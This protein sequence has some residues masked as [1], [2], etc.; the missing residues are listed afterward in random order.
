MHLRENLEQI[1]I[2]TCI[3]MPKLLTHTCIQC[4]NGLKHVDN[5]LQRVIH[6]THISLSYII[7]YSHH[8]NVLNRLFMASHNQKKS[9]GFYYGILLH[10]H[11]CPILRRIHFSQICDKNQLFPQQLCH[12]IRYNSVRRKTLIFLVVNAICFLKCL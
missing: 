7:G 9:W 11:V 8:V 10:K 4:K 2:F 12:R 3:C 1:R 6:Q 5:D